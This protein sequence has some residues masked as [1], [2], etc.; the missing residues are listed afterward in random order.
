MQSTSQ[1]RLT[2]YSTT[3]YGIMQTTINGLTNT[4]ANN[5]QAFSLDV[6]TDPSQLNQIQQFSLTFTLFNSVYFG[7]G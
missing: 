3:N 7:E 4:I 6:I 5:L 1:L 2:A